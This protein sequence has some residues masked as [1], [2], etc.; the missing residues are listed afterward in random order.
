VGLPDFLKVPPPAEPGH[1]AAWRNAGLVDERGHVRL[2][3][4]VRSVL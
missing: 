1:E 3:A 4:T 2:R